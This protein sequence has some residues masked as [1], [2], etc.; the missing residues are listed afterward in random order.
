MIT[1]PAPDLLGKLIALRCANLGFLTAAFVLLRAFGVRGRML[2]IAVL[3]PAMF[4]QFVAN[5]HNDAIALAVLLAAAVVVRRRPV[6][7]AG[8]VSIAG[9]VKLPF[10][11]LGLPLFSG[12]RF[13][14]RVALCAAAVAATLLFSWFG[15]GL[16]YVHALSNFGVAP[17]PWRYWHIPAVLAAGAFLAVAIAGGRRYRSAVWIVPAIGAFG[18][19]YVYPWYFAW[20]LAYALQRRRVLRHL[21]AGFPLAAALMQHEFWSPITI[22]VIFPIVTAALCLTLPNLRARASA[23]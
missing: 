11:V 20:G 1:A 14:L 13:P 7:A 9:L 19:P 21:L 3:N 12:V 17:G 23:A 6:V 15:G 2:A 8:L 22:V 5:A 4:F 10:A 16:P 18:I